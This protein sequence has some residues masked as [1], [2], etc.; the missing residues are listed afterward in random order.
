ME[1]EANT[2][3][4][5]PTRMVLK[6]FTDEYEIRLPD[7]YIDFLNTGNCGVPKK[8]VFKHKGNEFL[9]ER[10]LS[11]TDYNESF[12]ETSHFDIRVVMAQ[13]E[14]RLTDNEDLVGAEI[15]PIA[16]L[17]AGDFVC[18]DFREDRNDP[19]IVLWDHNQSSPL[20]PYTEIISDNFTSFLNMLYEPKDD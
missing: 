20:S 19:K 11:I 15:L 5:P 4:L 18:L 9:I 16:Y 12:P 6:E 17:F 7:D 10:F 2:T 8:Q 1:F 13:I 3:I 14:D